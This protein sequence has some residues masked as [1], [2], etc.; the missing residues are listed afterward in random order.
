MKFKIVHEKTGERIAL[1][2]DVCAEHPQ[3]VHEQCGTTS[4]GEL[5]SCLDQYDI[6]CY[7]DSDGDH[8]GPDICG[9]SMVFDDAAEAAEYGVSITTAPAT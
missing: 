7:Y 1:S 5:Q 8:K 4:E 3:W 2:R 6:R 9:I